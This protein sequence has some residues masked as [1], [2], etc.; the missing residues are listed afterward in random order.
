MTDEQRRPDDGSAGRLALVGASP[1]EAWARPGAARS[2]SS[3]GR[4]AVG[5]GRAAARRSAGPAPDAR[6]AA[7]REPTARRAP[8]VRPLVRHRGDRP[9]PLRPVG[10][11]PTP[12]ARTAGRPD[13]PTRTGAVLV[14]LAAAIALVAGVA[15]GAAG[16]LLA[17]RDDDGVTVDGANLGSAPA[18]SVDR[19]AGS[20][21]GVAAQVL[22]SVVQ[23]KVD[24][25]EG[26]AT[27]SGFVA[28]R[29]GPARHQQPRRRRSARATST[30]SFSDG[31]TADRRR[32]GDLGELRHRGAAGGRAEPARA[33]ARQLRLA[34]SSATRSSRSARRWA[35]PAPSPA[36]SSARRTARSP[37]ASEGGERQRLHQRDPDRRRH[38][39]GQL[40]RAA[41]QPRG[42]GRSASTPRSPP[43]AAA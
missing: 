26:E 40:R 20:I 4:A 27:G 7:D 32:R 23:I 39:P 16:Y 29:R 15:G 21:P 43:S 35:C 25:A 8:R 18:R 38:Q 10:R 5:P 37:R 2:P 41:G 17:E 19:P 36:A 42:R 12:S 24:T 31:T 3:P 14:A 28:G 33:A 6:P 30:V 22:P 11:S 34:S 1:Q 13:R 9:R